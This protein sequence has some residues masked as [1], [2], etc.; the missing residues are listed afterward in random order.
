MKQSVVY[1]HFRKDEMV[2]IDRVLE[3]K[4]R[5]E[6]TYVPVVT[7]FLNPREQFIL[8]S[9]LPAD[10]I[11]KVYLD[12]G[13]QDS[14]RKRAV[15]TVA[16]DIQDDEFSIDIVSI[17]YPVKFATLKHSAILGSILGCGIQREQVGDIITDGQ[18]WQMVVA[19]SVSGY[20]RDNCRKIGSISV[21][22]QT[23]TR[24]E[25]IQSINEYKVVQTTVS[26]L[27]LD[28]LVA[29]AFN[30]SRQKAKELIEQNHVTINWK[31]EDKTHAVVEQFDV[32]S[33]RKHGRVI[34]SRLNGLTK[35]EKY[36]IEL[37]VLKNR[38]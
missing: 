10:D 26:S 9:L 15:L 8:K 24:A 13:F 2:F 28:A 36:K 4:Q 25:R 20:I 27:R 22:L 23:V 11:I 6:D 35:N 17:R 34:V 32:I 18:N 21:T 3:W 1:Q 5:V 16:D 38:R 29:T 31:D 14:E 7:P 37:Q 19:H 33:V 30:I 12:G